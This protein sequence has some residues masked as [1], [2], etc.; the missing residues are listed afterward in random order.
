MVKEKKV[1]KIEREKKEKIK[2][3]IKKS[4]KGPRKEPFKFSSKAKKVEKE[5]SKSEEV[6]QKEKGGAKGIF[7]GTYIYAVGRRKCATST[8]RLF[9]EGE[10]KIFI[11]EKKFEDYFPVFS[12]QKIITAPLEA[13]DQKNKFNISVKVKG[14]GK[15]GQAE[16]VRLAIT[17]ALIKLSPDFRKSL[18]KQGFLTR[19]SRVKERKKYGLK[20]ARR[21]PQW[22]KR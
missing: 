4:K 3:I 5:I 7:K 19:D 17:R 14:G 8:V 20:R 21:A 11:N 15:K 13:A 10:G 6:S 2:K 16:S 22:Q 12:L 9:K 18:K 1:K